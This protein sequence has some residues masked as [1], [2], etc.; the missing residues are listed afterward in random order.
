[1]SD[2]VLLARPSHKLC[3]CSTKFDTCFTNGCAFRTDMVVVYGAITG[4]LCTRVHGFSC[5]IVRDIKGNVTTLQYII[6]L[7]TIYS[8]VPSKLSHLSLIVPP[9]LTISEIFRSG[10]TTAALRM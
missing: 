10:I 8:H 4:S 1:M 3:V 2:E 6:S 7:N 9:L 5:S